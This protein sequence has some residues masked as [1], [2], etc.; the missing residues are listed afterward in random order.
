MRNGV[1]A[2]IVLLA[3]AGL[4]AQAPT[5]SVGEGAALADQMQT[6]L[7]SLRTAVDGL[8]PGELHLNQDQKQAMRDSQASLD[9]NLTQA[10]P[11]L[12]AAYRAAPDDVGAAFRLYRDLDAVLGVAQR[13]AEAMSVRDADNGQ[14][15]LQASADQ[16]RARLDQLGDWIETQGSANYA[17]VQGL[18]VRAA[19]AAAKPVAAAPKTL[20]I[21]DANGPAPSKKTAPK[22]PH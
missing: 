22:I 15:A 19:A 14:A 10:A 5:P 13:S 9:R 2:W 3:A 1:M 12:L 7:A 20:V 11:G 17:S 18:R 21:H 8:D 6:A 4:W 16:L